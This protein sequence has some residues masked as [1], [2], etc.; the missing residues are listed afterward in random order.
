MYFSS[1]FFL[2]NVENKSLS[3]ELDRPLSS[4]RSVSISGVG[5]L[6]HTITD[7]SCF[8]DH[9]KM[10]VEKTWLRSTFVKLYEDFLETCVKVG[11]YC[12]GNTYDPNARSA[13]FE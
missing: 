4:N 2:Q 8:P 6:P 13:R 9:D 11:S 1:A 10:H 3:S 7:V 5:E 12:F